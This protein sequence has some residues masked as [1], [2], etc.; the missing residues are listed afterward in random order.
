MRTLYRLSALAALA[1]A[2]LSCDRR[3]TF[4]TGK[5]VSLES[6]SISISESV[7]TF[8]IPVRVYANDGRDFAVLVRSS[9]G[10]ATYG[11]DYELVGMESGRIV[12][13]GTDETRSITVRILPHLSVFTD[14]LDFT[15]ELVSVTDGTLGMNRT[16]RVIIN[17]DD[18]PLKDVI[19]TYTASGVGYFTGEAET[20][21]LSL[22]SVKG[23]LTSVYVNG[24]TPTFVGRTTGTDDY[25]LIAKVSGSVGRRTV[26]LT[27]GTPLPSQLEGETMYLWSY[28][29]RGLNDRGS[30]LFTQDA[31]TGVY[32][33]LTGYGIGYPLEDGSTVSLVDLFTPEANTWTKK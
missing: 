17:D 2:L 30:L 8:E 23:D 15:V 10:T 6:S 5:Y 21:T 31:A 32:T 33:C 16:I 25:R 4:I 13:G 27:A 19:G 12:F 24:I 11:E 9:D 22:E 18:H 7:G 26:T 1:A 28:S 3:E 14:D 29:A 20:W